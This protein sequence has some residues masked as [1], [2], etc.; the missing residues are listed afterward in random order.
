MTLVKDTLMKFKSEE[1]SYKGAVFNTGGSRFFSKS[2]VGDKT[3]YSL[4]GNIY[5]AE[6]GDTTLLVKFEGQF[7][8]KFGS[9]YLL[10]KLDPMG[11]YVLFVY[12]PGAFHFFERESLKRIDLKSRKVTTVLYGAFTGMT[13]SND[14]NFLLFRRNEREGANDTWLSDI[15]ILDLHKSEQHKI[16]NAYSAQWS[17]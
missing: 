6:G 13:F 5:L 8:P 2:T 11:S 14:G 9:G 3:V 7:D 1:S 15:F 17:K 12:A 16:G 10:P 4:R